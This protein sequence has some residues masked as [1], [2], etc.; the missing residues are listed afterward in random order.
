MNITIHS[1]TTHRLFINK[2]QSSERM[3]DRKKN[4][5]YSPKVIKN[6]SN[7]NFVE[8]FYGIKIKEKD[9]NTFKKFKRCLELRERGLSKR[10][11]AK[12]I[13]TNSTMESAKV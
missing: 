2:K 11:I 1:S 3:K 9:K 10:E 12:L 13:W 6:L 5:L 7:I 4:Q 8:S